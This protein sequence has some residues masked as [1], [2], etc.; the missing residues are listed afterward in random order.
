MPSLYYIQAACVCNRNNV[1]PTRR[2]RLLQKSIYLVHGRC[3]RNLRAR[4]AKIDDS[5][6]FFEA[7]K[8]RVR[9]RWDKYGTARARTFRARLRAVHE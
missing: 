7:D 5:D 2:L 3:V 6:E 9:S 1:M 4:A 8:N